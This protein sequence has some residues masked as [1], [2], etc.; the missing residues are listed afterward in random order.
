MEEIRIIPRITEKYED[1]SQK[2]L[3]NKATFLNDM[4]GSKGEV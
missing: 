1:C 3:R 4:I 2:F